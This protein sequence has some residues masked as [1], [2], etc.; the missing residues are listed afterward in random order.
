M[1]SSKKKPRVKRV[2]SKGRKYSRTGYRRAFPDLV[3]DF[4]GRCA[5]SMRHVDV[6]GDVT[7][8]IDHFNPHQKNHEIQK[9]ENLYLATLHCNLAKGD[10]WPTTSEKRSGIRLLD[11]CAETEYG[12]VIFE[13]SDGVLHGTTP[14]AKWHIRKLGLNASHL[15]IERQERRQLHDLLTTTLARL[16]GKYLDVQKAVRVLQEQLQR[17]IPMILPVEVHQ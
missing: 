8:N 14:T 12:E 6:T 1:S 3:K 11:P 13:D 16:T 17:K 15:C 5:Y 4:E 10:W 9:G 7:M 2:A